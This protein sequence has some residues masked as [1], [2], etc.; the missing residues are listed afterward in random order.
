VA[1]LKGRGAGAV[2]SPDLALCAVTL[3][4][5][6]GRNGIG[7]GCMNQAS[8]PTSTPGRRS[9]AFNQTT[10]TRFQPRPT[11]PRAASP[12]LQ[13]PVIPWLS[14]S[15]VPRAGA[16]VFAPAAYSRSAGRARADACGQCSKLGTCGL[17]LLAPLEARAA[18][19]A[20]S[21]HPCGACVR[22]SRQPMNCGRA[23][24]RRAT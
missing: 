9:R 17:S 21:E 14:M 7:H 8:N 24:A 1:T 4:M 6:E 2:G 5:S 10:L 3:P 16:H 19:N 23:R 11:P 12:G 20:A 13:L 15:A 22:A 18:C